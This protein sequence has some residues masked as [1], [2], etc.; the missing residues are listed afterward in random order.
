MP[1]PVFRRGESVTL[2]PIEPEDAPYLV[3]L[4]NDPDVRRGTGRARPMS[5]ADEREWIE[6]LNDRNPDGTNLL[7]CADGD[8]VGTVGIADVVQPWGTG[9]L[10]YMIDPDVWNR[11][12]ATDAVREACRHAVEELRLAKLTARVY[13]TNPASAR[14]LEKLGFT[15]EGVLR[16]QALVDG[17]RVDVRLFGLL[18]EE[19]SAGGPVSR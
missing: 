2:H 3:T 10:G 11:G 17:E 9:E 14:V 16:R 8:P 1:G 7:V 18:A 15:E 13:E 19:L 5:E 12:Y 4:L 6:T